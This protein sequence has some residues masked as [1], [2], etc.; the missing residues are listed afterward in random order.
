M[1]E[2]VTIARPYAKAAFAE[3]RKTQRLRRGPMALA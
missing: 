2:R 3:A 1:T